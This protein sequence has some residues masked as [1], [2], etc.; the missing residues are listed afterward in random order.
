MDELGSRTILEQRDSMK[1][2]IDTYTTDAKRVEAH[3]GDLDD[4]HQQDP[5]AEAV[6]ANVP[7][8]P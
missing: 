4:F 7:A 8:V 6:Q 1:S 3:Y 2:S 5:L